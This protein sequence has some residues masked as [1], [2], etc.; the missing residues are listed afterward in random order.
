MI[1]KAA[2]GGDRNSVTQAIESWNEDNFH[3]IVADAACQSSA[4]DSFDA[5]KSSQ[6]HVRRGVGD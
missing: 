2:G 6:A 3:H 5:Q 1:G 4:A